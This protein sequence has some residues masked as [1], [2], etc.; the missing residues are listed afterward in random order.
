[1]A[2]ATRSP[3]SLRDAGTKEQ[4]DSQ[5]WQDSTMHTRPTNEGPTDAIAGE[6]AV[7]AG[8]LSLPIL[9][10]GHSAKAS[11][12]EGG[13]A[14]GSHGESASSETP[15]KV[16]WRSLDDKANTDEF[17]R[18]KHNEFQEGASVATDDERRTFMKLMGASAA[19]A[20]LAATGCRRLPEQ[21]ILPYAHR[22]DN[23]VPG[24]PVRYAT[25]YELGGM[26]YGVVATS[27]DGR[28]IKLDG[29]PQHPAMLGGS[30][31]ITQARVLEV[32]DPHRSRALT[33]GGK[34]ASID[35][36]RAWLAAM[37]A[38]G[39]AVLAE[40]SSSPSLA[41]MR[42]RLGKKFRSM[43]WFE[44][45]PI[46]DDNERAGTEL[47]FGKP[48][49]AIWDL[50]AAT[51]VVLSLDGDFLH[52]HSAAV[53][54]A[55]DFAATRRIEN[56]DPSKQMMSAL[57][58]VESAL[59]VTGMNADERIAV[60]SA[61]VAAV[62][63]IIAQKLSQQNSALG[64]LAQS[65]GSLTSAVSLTAEDTKI[66]DALVAALAGATGTSLVIAG[67]S[68]PA[69][70]HALAA[71]MNVALGNVGK[72]VRYV[73]AG[74]KT[75]SCLGD[76]TA[77]AAAINRG[78]VKTLAILGGNPV[79][80]AP[81]DIN[82]GSLM[83]KAGT[84][85]HLSFYRNETSN[86]ASCRWHVPQGHFLETWG[87]T[88]GAEGT[89]APQQPLIAPMVADGQGGLSALE[90]CAELLG[91]D[92]RDGYSIVR[93][94][95][96]GIMGREGAAFEAAW[97]A[98]LNDGFVA[99]SAYPFEQVAV[100]GAGLQS[101]VAALSV[102]AK[103]TE[104]TFARDAKVYDGRFANL[105]WLQELPDPVSKLT[106]DNAAY[107][108]PATADAL[109][110]KK[111]DMLSVSAGGASMQVVAWPMPGMA[112]DSVRVHL[113]Y[114]RTTADAGPIAGEAGFNAYPLRTSTAM[115][116]VA[117]V[118][119]SKGT[120]TYPLGH[121]QDHGATDA[122]IPSVPAQGIAERLPALIREDD[123][124]TYRQHK[125]FAKHRSHVAHRLSM[126]EENLLDGAKFRWAMAIDLTTCTGCSACVTACQAE[127]NIPVVGKEHVMRGR[128]MHWI[129]IDR[130]FK[131]P[132]ANRP[133][134][135]AIQPV[136]CMHCETAPCEQVCPVAAT[137]HDKEGLN[138][139]VYNRCIGTRYCSNNCPYKVR[140]FNFFDWHRKDPERDGGFMMVKPEY[141][142]RDG[143]N[144][145]TAMQF[146]PEVTVRM[147]GVMEKC[148]FC[149]Q[150]IQRAKITHKNAWAK[151][152]GKGDPKKAV[153]NGTPDWSI[154]DGSF[155]TACA[156]ACPSQ[157]I[158]FGDLNDPNS[159]VAKLHAS[160]LSY[161]LLEELNT[162]PR[163][164][165]LAKVRN[166][167]VTFDH[168][169]HGHDDEHHESGGSD[170]APGHEENAGHA[171]IGLAS[172]KEVRA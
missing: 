104:L 6:A 52:G 167:S 119:V 166:P 92:P 123:L 128:E 126:W 137:M 89:I 145:W 58:V 55:R 125:D 61:D 4:T 93:R 33:D 133:L 150:R 24:E 106:W 56:P 23:R 171:S 130:Y 76:I 124:G 138:V 83:A 22:P 49:R 78:E 103:G 17:L 153:S 12:S 91:E 26:G 115:G 117:G 105:A 148:S 157:A 127:N 14:C 99:G 20:G 8:S 21:H 113:G 77:L 60:R 131:G 107:L 121:T 69:A 118:S 18:W 38:D 7:D 116:F 132:D 44:W 73:A 143:A 2:A 152:G 172:S 59:S 53:R 141:Y 71:A 95:W 81:A 90:F 140:R 72:T 1:M 80:D 155:T 57:Y 109:G 51:G 63:A 151:S 67:D 82:F 97:R 47:A 19:L 75:R 41:D 79:Y 74:D 154:P 85:L 164:Q 28:P 86:H 32:Y 111:G 162:K 36:L 147:R 5:T 122:L 13:C 136:A 48:M 165:Y 70:V 144:P 30:D 64:G 160:P 120:G 54:S 84:V 146:N 169:G 29:N 35:N 50:T 139:M 135:V 98:A 168:T 31:S 68:Q 112:R 170:H 10:S 3:R 129:R 101:A 27:V 9:T 45:A 37:P 40:P 94:T 161:G 39:L 42:A 15:S 142:T 114:G 65:L 34:A 158:T 43:K 159:K 46:N 25:S 88:R 87:D 163:L 66:V 62:A 134:G 156:E 102:P 149:V 16:F 100:Q 96:Q 110:V 108:S 11:A